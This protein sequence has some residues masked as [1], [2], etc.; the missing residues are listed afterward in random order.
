[1]DGLPEATS[2]QVRHMENYF[3]VSPQSDLPRPC[4]AATASR[5][6]QNRP[7]LQVQ[8][9][10]SC[11]NLSGPSEANNFPRDRN[12]VHALFPFPPVSYTESGSRASSQKLLT[13]L[14]QLYPTAVRQPGCY[15]PSDSSPGNQHLSG[16]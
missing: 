6:L 10:N 9:W 12:Q 14:V 1:M 11:C 8:H 7:L 16:R 2:M 15:P 4:F 3:S 13:F 5:N